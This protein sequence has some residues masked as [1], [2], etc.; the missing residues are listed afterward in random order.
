[1][2]GNLNKKILFSNISAALGETQQHKDFE[3]YPVLDYVKDNLRG[4]CFEQ[5]SAALALSFYD[6]L[7]VDGLPDC[8]HSCEDAYLFN[9]MFIIELRFECFA[10]K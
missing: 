10:N 1:M 7:S 9:N 8:N 6:G 3:Q 5:A 2:H 4:L